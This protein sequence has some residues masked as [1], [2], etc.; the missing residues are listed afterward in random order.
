MLRAVT[1]AS[2]LFVASGLASSDAVADQQVRVDAGMT[3]SR[4]PTVDRNGTGF[5][6]EIKGLVNESLAIG[7]RLDMAFMYG[8]S[9]GSDDDLSFSMLAGALLKAEFHLLPGVVRPFVSAGAGLY[10]I[11][12]QSLTASSETGA[13]DF[14]GGRFFGV[15]PQI[16]VD[17]G[18]LRLAATY[19]IIVGADLEVMRLDTPMPSTSDL[20]QNYFSVELSFAFAAPSK[21]QPSPQ[22]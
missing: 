3:M 12:S 5:V 20:S 1:Y 19:N 21:P 17:L 7:G 9:V 8:G 18:R 4:V 13:L 11:G 10:N 6:V 2:L 16:G 22:H 15:A 14:R